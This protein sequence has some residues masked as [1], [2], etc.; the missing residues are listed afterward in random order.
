MGRAMSSRRHAE[1]PDAVFVELLGTHQIT[2]PVD[3]ASAQ[4]LSEMVFDSIR[5]DQLYDS[6]QN[7]AARAVHT[8][9]YE[10]FGESCTVVGWVAGHRVTTDRGTLT[11]TGSTT[12]ERCEVNPLCYGES[13]SGV[14]CLDISGCGYWYCA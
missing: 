13:N 8:H 1:S 14:R 2:L 12:C 10:L 7:Q 5:A 4:E 11:L 6:E 3:T 9:L